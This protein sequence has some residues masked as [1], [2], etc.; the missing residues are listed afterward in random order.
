MCCCTTSALNVDRAPQTAHAH[1]KTRPSDGNAGFTLIE[2]LVVIAIIAILI[3]LLIPAVQA[4]REAAN[5][6]RAKA[7]VSQIVAAENHLRQFTTDLAALA[8]LGLID[9][10]LGTG[11]K[12]GYHFAVTLPDA[13]GF[14]V[15]AVPAAPGVTGSCDVRADQTGVVTVSASEGADA[16]R[17]AMFTAIDSEAATAI[18]RQWSQAPTKL[19]PAVQHFFQEGEVQEPDALRGVFKRLDANGD[20]KVTFSEILAYNKNPDSPLGAFLASVGR[21]LQLGLA[22]EDVASLPGVGLTDLLPAVQDHDEGQ[23]HVRVRHGSSSFLTSGSQ[24]TATLAG[25]CDGSVR[26]AD[27]NK[28][29]LDGAQFSA[30][31]PAVTPQILSG[32]FLISGNGGV[33]VQGILIGLLRS[34]GKSSRQSLDGFFLVTGGSGPAAG[35]FG[36]GRAS[37]DWG[38]AKA[39][40]FGLGLEGKLIFALPAVQ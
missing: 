10:T 9:P 11:N 14:I 36:S 20:A 6:N 40:T 25:F 35:A 30:L 19:L 37:I 17:A 24:T 16:A 1:V 18:G 39:N 22:N 13:G 7:D 32:R 23:F 31:L 8:Q 15:T 27:H 28:V 38:D 12:D 26:I 3:G 4:V 21:I 33:A 5:C 34:E 29:S 2:L